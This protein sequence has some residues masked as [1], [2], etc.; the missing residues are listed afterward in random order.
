MLLLLDSTYISPIL[1]SL[2]HISIIIAVN[3][4]DHQ[5]DQYEKDHKCAL[6]EEVGVNKIAC[7]K[8]DYRRLSYIY[9]VPSFKSL[10]AFQV[11][12]GSNLEST[13]SC[14]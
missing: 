1:P 5:N 9:T 11:C 4:N 12:L 8:C 6:E 2:L 7:A 14:A 3:L 13:Y 10:Q